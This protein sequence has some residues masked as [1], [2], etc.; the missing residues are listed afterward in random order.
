[1]SES[2]L[3][4]Y[5]FQNKHPMKHISFI[6]KM[7]PKEVMFRFSKDTF[8]TAINN[9]MIGG[10]TEKYEGILQCGINVVGTQKFVDSVNNKLALGYF[11]SDNIPEK[12]KIDSKKVTIDY[13]QDLG[14]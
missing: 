12:D 5:A 6:I 8:N 11:S 4:S 1:M 9:M 10:W 14:K 2:P 3:M 13:K 7:R